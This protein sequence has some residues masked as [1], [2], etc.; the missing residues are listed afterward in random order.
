M[1]LFSTVREHTMMQFITQSLVYEPI[2]I[3]MPIPVL[4]PMKREYLR[5][6]CCSSEL[7]V[8]H[9]GKEHMSIIWVTDVNELAAGQHGDY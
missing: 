6:K 3:V 7:C 8:Y 1:P 5:N 4:L 2:K 9:K